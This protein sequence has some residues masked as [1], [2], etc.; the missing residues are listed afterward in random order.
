MKRYV[1]LAAIVGILF[2]GIAVGQEKQAPA[3]PA[4]PKPAPQAPLAKLKDAFEITPEQEAKL[5]AFREARQNE[6]KAFAEQMKKFRDDMQA[7]RKDP[8]ADPNKVNA[9]ID[10]M[11]KLRADRA[12]AGI[13]NNQEWQKIFTP[14]QLEKMKQGRNRLLGLGFMRGLGQGRGMMGPGMRMMFRRGMGRGPI[15]PGGFMGPRIGRQGFGL[16]GPGFMAPRNRILR[17]IL[18]NR[19]NRQ[20][21]RG[22]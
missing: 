11:F 14:E 3:P 20:F 18:M 15:G 1:T 19:L 2:A 6:N 10:Q 8:K 16:R 12:K 9:L 17:F 22:W 4:K 13:R 5:K 7:F 21:P